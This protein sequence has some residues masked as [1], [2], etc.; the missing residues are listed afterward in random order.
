MRRAAAAA[1]TLAIAMAPAVHAGRA[2]AP[3]T[4]GDL[5]A[6][7][8]AIHRDEPVAVAEGQ[9]ARSYEDFLRD[10]AADPV[11]RAQAL[12]RLGDLRLAEAEDCRAREGTDSPAASQATPPG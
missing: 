1:L 11:L 3:A 10:P 4:L 12:R 7:S 2:P 8:V 9:A 6:R 5:A